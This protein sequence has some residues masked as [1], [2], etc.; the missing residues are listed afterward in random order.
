MPQIKPEGFHKLKVPRNSLNIAQ[1]DLETAK[2][3]HTY[4]NIKVCDD[5]MTD[6]MIDNYTI[7]RNSELNWIYFLLRLQLNKI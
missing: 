6:S 3:R 2:K 5:F 1:K 4:G 7:K